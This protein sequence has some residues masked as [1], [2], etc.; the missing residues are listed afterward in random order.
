[1]GGGQLRPRAIVAAIVLALTLAAVAPVPTASAAVPVL[2]LDGRGWG[3]GVGLSQ[4]GSRYLAEGG[5]AF[6][7][8]LGLF[9]PGTQLGS[10]GGGVRVA[11]Y[12]STDGTASVALPQGGELRS[13][14]EGDQAPGFPMAIAP[15]GA[16]SIRFDGIYHASAVMTAQSAARAQRVAET[17]VTVVRPCST[18]TTTAGG[19]GGGGCV[20]RCDPTTTTAAG[21]EPPPPSETTPPTDTGA[22]DAGGAPPVTDASS[23][24]PVWVVPAGGGVT[25]VP[26][27][28]R[29]YRGLVEAT[30]ATGSLRLVNSLDVETYLTGLA[31]MPSTW[32][33]PALQAQVVAARTYALRAMSFSG[34]LCDHQACQVYVGA[35]REDARQ[36]AAVRD[37]AGVVL[38]YGGALASAVYSADAGGVSATTQEGFGTPEGVYPYL[39]TVRYDTPNP[40]PWHLEVSLADV[41][42]R[43]GYAG[44]ISSVTVSR[45]GPSGRALEVALDGSAGPAA[46][47]GRAFASALGLRSTLFAA[48][49]G[50]SAT[51]PAPPPSASPLQALPEDAAAI[52][53]AARSASPD[54][55]RA[56]LFAPSRREAAARRASPPVSGR[57]IAT[58]AYVAVAMLGLVTA[59]GL[60]RVRQ[61]RW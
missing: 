2:V 29:A 25:A 59:L 10:A 14:L 56:A 48:S 35:T 31:E 40:L 36:S 55:T 24:S 47:D 32:V 12:S 21:S 13:P 61:P 51:A 19:G 22:P 34:E 33:A 38:T 27:R 50:T 52:T 26:A 37:T 44:S 18:T 43:V 5:M 8:I 41:A 39:T 16:V 58:A 42:A 11:V 23:A 1:M 30:A 57:D 46:V 4:F 53:S 28:E 3:H 60:Q 49:M 17:C 6:E 7:D 15:G 54:D 9:Y 20:L 45:A